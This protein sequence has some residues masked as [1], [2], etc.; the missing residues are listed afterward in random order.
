MPVIFISHGMPGMAL[1]PGPTGRFLSRLPRTIEMPRAI[2]CVSAHLEGAQALLTTDTHPATLHDFGNP[3]PALRALHY[4]APGEPELARR[5]VTLLTDE[6][7]AAQGLA[8]RGLDHGAW[9]PLSLMYPAADI[10][11]V[12]LSVQTGEPPAYHLALG[13]ALA[14]LR[15]DDIMILASGGATHDLAAMVAHRRDDPPAAY[16]EAFDRW[17]AD[18]LTTGDTAA[19]LDY[20]R[21][22]PS[23]ERNHP[24][25]A[26][27]FLPLIVA[28]GAGGSRAA[29]LH[30]R[31][32]YG[33][34]SL[35][36]Y[37]WD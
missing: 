6:G 37:R 24:Y 19:L 4:P 9:V 22:A 26:E 28:A 16:A 32:E 14:A 13:Q 36:A 27:H 10:P 7:V 33:V 35:A 31:F 12:Q 23:A 11:V 15:N 1:A 21:A 5:I 34:L 8:D 2:V 20:R 17:L 18:I 29:C 30:R 25:P 3:S